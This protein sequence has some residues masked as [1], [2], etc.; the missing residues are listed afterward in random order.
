MADNI[1]DMTELRQKQEAKD[2]AAEL[3]DAMIDVCC[4]FIEKM[5]AAGARPEQIVPMLRGLKKTRT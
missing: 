3:S 2:I 1:V 4:E 5:F